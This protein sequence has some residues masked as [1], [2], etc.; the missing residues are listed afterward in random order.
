MNKTQMLKF[1]EVENATH[2]FKPAQGSKGAPSMTWD[3]A[4][5]TVVQQVLDWVK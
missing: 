3:E 4:Q 1:I 5:K 2:G